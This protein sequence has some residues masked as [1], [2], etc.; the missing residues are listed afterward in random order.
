[1]VK[2]YK[3]CEHCASMIVN[4]IFIHE[5][6]CPVLGN[7]NDSS[8]H[9]YKTMKAVD[10]AIADGSWELPKTLVIEEL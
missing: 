4:D 2:R 8:S 7:P 10:R 3:R 1:M 6:G 5:N 9:R